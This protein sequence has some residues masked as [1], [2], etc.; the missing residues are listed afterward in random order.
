V[1]DTRARRFVD[2]L[3][4]A[5]ARILH[6]AG[7]SANAVTLLAALIGVCAAVL[8]AQDHPWVGLTALWLSGLLDA[9]DGALAR[10]TR[11]SPIGAILDITLDR[12]VELA[13]V[14]ALAWRYPQARLLLVALA[15]TIAVAMSLFLSIAA[16]LRNTS[17]KAFH[18]APGLGERTE[19]FICLSLMAADAERLTTWTGVFLAIMVYTM[20]QRLR[21]AMRRLGAEAK[22][23][24]AP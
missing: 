15:A 12:V 19:A 1:L 24:P 14:F 18:Y 3:I 17:T 22:E 6:R 21:H 13:M 4:D 2:P 16:A 8:V 10:M 11:S 20:L 5:V 9:A 7:L 23:D